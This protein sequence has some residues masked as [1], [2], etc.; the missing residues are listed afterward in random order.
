MGD[1]ALTSVGNVS[2]LCQS[3]A[4]VDAPSGN[5]D[6]YAADRQ[7]DLDLPGEVGDAEPRWQQMLVAE[8]GEPVR[9]RLVRPVGDGVFMAA[10]TGQPAT[11]DKVE[12]LVRH[13]G[14]RAT[15]DPVRP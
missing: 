15:A 7:G 11:T 5:P 3:C 1:S 10:L 8:L 13:L 2:S 12:Q 6:E 14:L 4:S 9:A